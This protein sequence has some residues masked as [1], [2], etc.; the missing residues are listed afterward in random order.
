MVKLM[1]AARN[2]IRDGW[3]QV[4]SPEVVARGVHEAVKTLLLSTSK[5]TM[6]ELV[7]LSVLFCFSSVV[8]AGS[9]GNRCE[10]DRFQ[11]LAGPVLV[12]PEI[13]QPILT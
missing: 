10:Q 8:L 13:R 12:L 2:S 9:C 1:E 5:G 11:K 6:K 7:I 4:R 3:G